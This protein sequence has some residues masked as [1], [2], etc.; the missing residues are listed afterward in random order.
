MIILTRSKPLCLSPSQ[1]KHRQCFIIFS[2]RIS[3]ATT[4][5]VPGATHTSALSTYQKSFQQ[6]PQPNTLQWWSTT[7][8]MKRKSSGP[9]VDKSCRNLA[10]SMYSA[11]CLR[12]CYFRDLH[13]TITTCVHV[14]QRFDRHC[15]YVMI[16]VFYGIEGNKRKVVYVEI[17]D[18]VIYYREAAESE[19][20]WP[21]SKTVRCPRCEGDS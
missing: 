15:A 8:I 6:I 9:T 13:P 7:G 16:P 21:S 20:L 1:R 4:C 12:H 18:Y 11:Q 14:R 3:S 19:S 2:Y 5:D 10:C 17:R